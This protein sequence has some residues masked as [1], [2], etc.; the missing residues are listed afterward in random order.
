MEVTDCDV[1]RNPLSL[2]HFL[3]LSYSLDPTGC[4]T[5]QVH[6]H[7][8]VLSKLRVQLCFRFTL[9]NPAIE[10]EAVCVGSHSSPS[11]LQLIANEIDTFRDCTNKHIV[12]YMGSFLVSPYLH[13]SVRLLSRK[14]SQSALFSELHVAPTLRTMCT[15]A[16]GAAHEHSVVG[17]LG[18][19][20]M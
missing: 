14:R 6:H 2:S 3:S 7:F 4:Q 11:L 13:V 12:Q 1:G 15:C 5:P 10:T 19:P 20:L 8:F 16:A 9:F 18:G 17:M